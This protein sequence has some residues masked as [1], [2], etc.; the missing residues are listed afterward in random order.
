MKLLLY[1]SGKFLFN[2]KWPEEPEWTQ[3][4]GGLYKERLSQAIKEAVV[5]E[6]QE[7]VKNIFLQIG[8]LWGFKEGSFYELPANWT[9]K[10]WVAE[11]K[12]YKQPV[13]RL[14][15][16]V[17]PVEEPVN[18]ITDEIIEQAMANNPPAF[19]VSE[20]KEDD[21]KSINMQPDKIDIYV[22]E[23]N[24]LKEK[25]AKWDALYEK[26][27]KYYGVDEEGNPTEKEGD[28]GTIGEIVAGAFGFP[29]K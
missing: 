19:G 2:E 8:T 28:L 4:Y 3:K 17:L 10:T 26:I 20:G 11:T 29:I 16:K 14:V 22:D 13:T 6:N 12:M 1:T 24:S 21:N 7:E 27:G 23:Y 5:V 9:V 18:G 15:A 25:A